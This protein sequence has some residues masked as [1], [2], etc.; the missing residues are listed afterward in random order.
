MNS[1]SLLFWKGIDIEFQ[2]R[3]NID[4]T[5]NFSEIISISDT[6]QML[7]IGTKRL[8]GDIVES[9]VKYTMYRNFTSLRLNIIPDDISCDMWD[10]TKGNTFLSL[11]F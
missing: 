6:K 8:D 11:V 9:F 4:R 1:S 2:V 3:G 10:I 5:F 7:R